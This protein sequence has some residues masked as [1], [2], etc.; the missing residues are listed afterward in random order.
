MSLVSVATI[1]GTE[2]GRSDQR[3]SRSPEFELETV[4]RPVWPLLELPVGRFFRRLLGTFCYGF[5][6]PTGDIA[7]DYFSQYL[8]YIHGS[9]F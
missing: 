5:I 3:D 6:Y 2:I 4:L 9:E 8:D 1:A 7:L